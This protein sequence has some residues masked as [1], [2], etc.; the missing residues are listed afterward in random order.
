MVGQARRLN[1]ETLPS[2]EGWSRTTDLRERTRREADPDAL[3]N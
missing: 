2:G 3:T 1:G